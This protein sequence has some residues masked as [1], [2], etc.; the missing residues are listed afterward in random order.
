MALIKLLKSTNRT[1]C[2]ELSPL[3]MLFTYFESQFYEQKHEKKFGRQ[4]V[5]IVCVEC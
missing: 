5:W 2:V 3:N 1:K 4:F